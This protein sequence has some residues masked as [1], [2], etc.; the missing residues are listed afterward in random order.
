MLSAFTQEYSSSDF[1]QFGTNLKDFHGF[2]DKMAEVIRN[3]VKPVLMKLQDQRGIMKVLLVTDDGVVISPSTDVDQLSLLANIQTVTILGSQ[4][5]KFYCCTISA[6][7]H[8]LR[9]RPDIFQLFKSF[10]KNLIATLTDFLSISCVNS[11]YVH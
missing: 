9:C 7:P 4:I 3:S 5:S 6:P 1:G 8:P 2:H 11:S 10:F